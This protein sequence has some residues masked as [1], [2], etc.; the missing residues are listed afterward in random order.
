MG[1]DLTAQARVVGIET[2]FLNL[3][4]DNVFLLPQQVGLIGPGSTLATYALTPVQYTTAAA[5]GAAYGTG[6]P[7]HLAA[8][9]LLPSNGDGL[10][11]VPLT[12]YPLDDADGTTAA[13][14]DITMTGTT[15]AVATSYVVDING[16]LSAPFTVDV[17]D[18]LTEIAAAMSTAINGNTAMPVIATPAVG[19][20]TLVAKSLGTWGNDIDV[21]VLGDV[22]AN[23][24]ITVTNPT[25][26]AGNQTVQPALDQIVTKWET[27]IVSCFEAD[28][29]T[30]ANL[31]EIWGEGRWGELV[32]KPAVVYNGSNESSTATLAAIG[33]AR[34]T[35]RTN[36]LL[37]APGSRSLPCQIAARAVARDAVLANNNPPRDYAGRQLSGLLVGVDSDQWNYAQRDFLIKAGISTT[38]VRDGVVTQS[39]TVTYYHP[40]GEDPPAFRY[41]VDIVKLQNVIFNLELIF[42]TD[43]W[44]GAPLIPD[45]QATTNKSARKPKDAIA[46]SNTMID[47]LALQAI[48][49]NPAGA[50]PLTTA[51]IGVSNPKRLD[52]SVTVQLSG[53]AN[54]ISIDLNFGFFFGTAAIV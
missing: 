6:S 29:I 26:G 12:V 5:V 28:D 22:D 49:S 17:G 14:G 15:Q 10:G 54:I 7:L 35:D 47:G 33:N 38:I 42:N 52:V 3:R 31:Y 53:N 36:V 34:L 13:S 16:I 23:I 1:V 41:V 2:N 27:M 24:T 21:L 8:L 30:N 25:G 18:S 20:V 32:K 40:A 48:L 46:A 43:E 4:G 50:K 39:D 45:D 37:P 19:V 44:D 11:T 9:Q 51:T